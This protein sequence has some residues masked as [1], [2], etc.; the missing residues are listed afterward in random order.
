[1]SFGS[2]PFVLRINVGRA[3]ASADAVVAVGTAFVLHPLC[4][5]Y[6]SESYC[7][8]A[9]VGGRTGLSFLFWQK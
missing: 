7:A 9:V 2:S 3:S 5:V 4:A 1:M 8:A 6:V